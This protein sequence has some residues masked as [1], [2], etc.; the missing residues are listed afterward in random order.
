MAFELINSALLLMV[1]LALY[2]INRKISRVDRAT[3]NLPIYLDTKINNAE[4]RLYQQIEALSGLN[5]LIHP[6]V[7]LPPLRGWASSPDFLLELARK[8]IAQKPT[9][10]VE[11]SC[12]A[13]TLVSA[14]ACQLIGSGH[15][16][17][18]E[19]EPKFAQET[20]DRL[21]EAGLEQWA[22]VIDAPLEMLDIT[23]DA[24]PWYALTALP[25]LSIDL[26]VVDGPPGF[27]RPLARYPAGPVLIPHLTSGAYVL[28]DDASR[29]DEKKMFERW[30]SEFPKLQHDSRPTEQGLV[31]LSNPE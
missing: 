26:L 7:P 13:S 22:S 19:H 14:Y 9:T 15:V 12:G 18:L 27:L 21:K 11:C 23:G 1:F 28:I 10:I 17:S 29:P 2:L 24:F 8:V 6:K 3:W 4:L 16:Y 30:L 25:K 20:R 5:A 31:I